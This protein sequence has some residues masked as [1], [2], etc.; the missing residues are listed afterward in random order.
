MTFHPY[1]PNQNSTIEQI[2]IKETKMA[3][4]HISKEEENYI[5]L[6]LL[7]TTSTKVVRV[8][9]DREFPP[10]CLDAIINNEQIK[11]NEL[12][13]KRFINES[14]SKLLKPGSGTYTIIYNQ[15]SKSMGCTIISTFFYE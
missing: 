15:M 3:T 2:V 4:L 6:R 7:V 10:P 14:Q 12:K 13:K 9:F 8:L 5:R 1:I 11:L